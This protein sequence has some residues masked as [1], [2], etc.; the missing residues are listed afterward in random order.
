MCWTPQQRPRSCINCWLHLHP[1]MPNFLLETM[2]L[3]SGSLSVPVISPGMLLAAPAASSAV[4][5]P[6]SAHMARTT[7]CV[8]ARPEVGPTAAPPCAFPVSALRRST[9][10]LALRS[11]GSWYGALARS[12]SSCL[13]SC[14]TMSGRFLPNCCSAFLISRLL[15]MTPSLRVQ[16]ACIINKG[17]GRYAGQGHA[18][19]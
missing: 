6:T 1:H 2:G 18:S 16:A 9:A 8:L 19:S 12:V 15:L 4:A 13:G 11:R 5:V 14:R 17:A 10:Y 7:S 3:G